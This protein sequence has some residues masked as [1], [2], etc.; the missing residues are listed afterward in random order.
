M[1]NILRSIYQERASESTTLG[2]LLIEKRE[3][4]ELVTDTFDEILV[5]FTNESS[6][7]I[8]GKHYHYE[9]KKLAFYVVNVEQVKEWLKT[10]SNRKVIDWL[11]YGKIVFD[12]NDYL[13]NLIQ[14]VKDFPFYERKQR[15]GLEFAK[16]IR[17][18]LEGKSLYEQQ[19]YLD[20]YSNIVHSLHHL[21]RLSLIEK[22]FHP[23]VTVWNQVKQIDAEVFKLYEELVYSDEPLNKRLDLLFL[24]SD[25]FIHSKTEIGASHILEVLDQNEEWSIQEIITHP[26]LNMYSSDLVVLLEYLVDKKYVSIELQESKGRSIYHRYYKR[27]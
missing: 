23:E 6:D 2:I 16:L 20:A 27:T 8:F 14:D 24:A 19:H 1:E 11:Y 21:G 25:F 10:G 13:Y 17:R 5:I 22:G 12:R 18:Y 7:P 15:I 26:E 4:L 3:Y 9:G